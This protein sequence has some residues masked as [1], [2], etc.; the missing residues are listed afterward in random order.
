M[1]KLLELIGKYIPVPFTIALLTIAGTFLGVHYWRG[2]RD[3]SDTIRDRSF[4][5]LSIII[6]SA[7]CLFLVNRR[8]APTPSKPPLLVVPL[9]QN[10]ERDQYRKAFGSQLEQSLV[11]IGGDAGSIYHVQA[12]LAEQDSAMQSAKHYGAT[13]ALYAPIVIR[14]KDSVKA[15][16][17]IAFVGADGSKPFA[18]VPLEVPAD[19]LDEISADLL[20]ASADQTGADRRNPIFT[21]MD[22]LE[23]QVTALRSALDQVTAKQHPGIKPYKYRQRQ[24]LVI[25]INDVPKAAFKLRYAVSDAKK[26]AEIL[27]HRFEFKTTVLLD[28]THS[29]V[30]ESLEKFQRTLTAEDLAIVYYSGPSIAQ[31][32]LGDAKELLLI[33]ADSNLEDSS[34]AMSINELAEQMQRFKAHH[35]LAILD[36]CHGTA[37]L[38]KHR[39]S[40]GLAAGQNPSDSVF[41]FFA[42][43]GDNEYGLESYQWGGGAFTHA[44]I[45]TFNQAAD[46]G[47]VL[48]MH[49]LVAQT[50]AVLQRQKL[51][52]QTPKIVTLSGSGE[53]SFTPIDARTSMQ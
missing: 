51:S 16:F 28:A 37:G 3:Y 36:G 49:E 43:T 24:A 34:A 12:F 32:Q 8:S 6:L 5:T 38:L 45:Q 29:A 33:F 1:E 22:A 21:R 20:G 14:G 30:V 23:K 44:L 9:F 48:W 18:M 47:Q 7:L 40:P 15:C 46:S 35:T 52:K 41:Q 31:P 50:A 53:I 25:G 26:F 10:D 13:A 19:V 42:G 39:L 4:L 27:H 2:F 17:H 11:R